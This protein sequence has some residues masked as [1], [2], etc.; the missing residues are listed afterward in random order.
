MRTKTLLL[1]AALAAAGAASTMAADVYSVNSVGYA[2]VSVLA[3]PGGGYNMIS[4]PFNV[5]D[6]SI[7]ALIPSGPPDQTLVYPFNNGNHQ[8]EGPWTY[9]GPPSVPAGQEFWDPDPTQGHIRH[10]GGAF[11]KTSGNFVVTFVGEVNQGN[12]VGATIHNNAGPGFNMM[13]SKV[14]QEAN[15]IALGLSNPPDQ[16]YIFKYQ[17]GPTEG[18]VGP[19]TYYGPPSVPAGQEFWDPDPSAIIF[20][21]GEALWVHSEVNQDWTRNFTVN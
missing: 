14:P 10:G 5:A 4:C 19:F 15:I 8:F 3:G 9:Y 1:T 18:Y 13:A 21:I 12:P 6:D 20:K 17:N 7:A 16:T 11:I 2:N